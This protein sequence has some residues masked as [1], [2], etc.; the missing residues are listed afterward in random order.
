MRRPPALEFHDRATPGEIRGTLSALEQPEDGVEVVT[1][2]AD[3]LLVCSCEQGAP[4]QHRVETPG[5]LREGVEQLVFLGEEGG[6]T[7][8]CLLETGVEFQERRPERAQPGAGAGG[9]DI[10][11][12]VHPAKAVRAAAGLSRGAGDIEERPHQLDSGSEKPPAPH[13][14]KGARSRPAE[15]P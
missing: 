14:S 9:I 10:V 5:A 4:L 6:R 3:P 1:F 11:R 8:E 7:R 15:E 12:I 13:T 2:G